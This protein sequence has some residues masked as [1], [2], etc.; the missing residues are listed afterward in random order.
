MITYSYSLSFV[1]TIY[2]QCC[3]CFGPA[4]GKKNYCGT[5]CTAKNGGT[6]VKNVYTWFWVRSSLPKRVWN[7]CMEYKVTVAPGK[8][9]W[10]KLYHGNNV[11][12]LVSFYLSSF[13][14]TNNMAIKSKL[15]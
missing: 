14:Y 13:F 3:G 2:Q 8:E 11:P 12:V 1:I 10:Y 9:V 4:G 5:E 15:L 7:K 6:I